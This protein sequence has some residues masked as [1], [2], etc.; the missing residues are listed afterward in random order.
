MFE[1]EELREIHHIDAQE[2]NSYLS[3]FF[4][5]LKK[6]ET[7]DYE[8]SSIHNIKGAIHSP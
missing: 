7:E 2:L 5:K 6:S 8:P 4:Y 3:E 1:K